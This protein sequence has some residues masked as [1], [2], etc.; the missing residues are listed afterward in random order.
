MR[1]IAPCVA[2]LVVATCVCG[3]TAVALP[4]SA[5]GPARAITTKGT[6]ATQASKTRRRSAKHSR[7]PSGKKSS[8]NVLLGYAAVESGLGSEAAGRSETFR[9]SGRRSGSVY[10]ISVYMDARNRATGWSRGCTPTQHGHPGSLLT[11]GALNH[12]KARLGIRFEC[13]PPRSSRGHI[14]WLAVL[15]RGGSLYFRAGQPGR[16]SAGEGT[17][18]AAA[19]APPL[20]DGRRAAPPSAASRHTRPARGPRA[21]STGSYRRSPVAPERRRGQRPSTLA[22][23]RSGCDAVELGV[24]GRGR[25]PW[26]GRLLGLG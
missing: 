24:R 9:F 14:Y 1:W 2:S 6:L 26:R 21:P 7:R 17:S 8:D 3:A 25:R 16:C 12:P 4:I 5:A 18:D 13:P 11:A 15:G 23:L 19:L 10:S 20:V 22:P